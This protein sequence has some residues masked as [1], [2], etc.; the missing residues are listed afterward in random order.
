MVNFKT[1]ALIASTVQGSMA[2]NNGKNEA[3]NEA[4]VCQVTDSNTITEPNISA[5]DTEKARLQDAADHRFPGRNYSVSFNGNEGKFT[6]V[7]KES[8]YE[9]Q[10]VSF[11]ANLNI[12]KY[13][14]LFIED[15]RGTSYNFY[16]SGEYQFEK[17]L[18]PVKVFVG[19]TARN[20]SG[21]VEI[22]DVWHIYKK[23]PI[24][25]VPVRDAQ[26]DKDL[27]TF[28]SPLAGKLVRLDTWANFYDNF[29]ANHCTYIELTGGDLQSVELD[30]FNSKNI[31]EL[32]A[33]VSVSI[34]H[35]C[36]TTRKEKEEDPFDVIFGIRQIEW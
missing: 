6:F 23:N 29:E 9:N 28:A 33:P 19:G 3:I 4:V 35:R 30:Q 26:K 27:I 2:P 12:D 11:K 34:K 24:I 1:V 20:R 25:E 21:S 15:G 17:L 22:T 16:K 14:R 7:G 5:C 36:F 13:G 8:W 10:L 18:A 31:V 32:T